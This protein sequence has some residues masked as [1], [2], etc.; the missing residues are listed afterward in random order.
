MARKRIIGFDRWKTEMVS[1][2]KLT[3]ADY[4]PRKLT[5]AR[6]RRL[7]A[8]LQ[9]FGLVQPII[10]NKRSG[11]VVGGHQRLKILL[12]AGAKASLCVTVN[13]GDEDERA[14]SV[15][16]NNPHAQGEFMEDLAPLLASL[17]KQLDA[18]FADL[19]LDKLVKE[20]LAAL[21]GLDVPQVPQ[22]VQLKPPREYVLVM[23]ADG[24]AGLEEFERLKVALKL[25]PVR[26][27]GYRKGSPFDDVGT[28]RVV[29]ARD[30]LGR[31]KHAH[32]HPK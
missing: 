6:A 22:A 5:P 4:N 27:G 12:D 11:R 20:R 24:D 32:R 29:H 14:L 28:Q 25:T 16:L 10:W 8:S 15:T 9:R 31:L 23:C 13:L 30:I 26:R 7:E 1:L 17:Q 18:S 2:S 19:G 21:Q 3:P